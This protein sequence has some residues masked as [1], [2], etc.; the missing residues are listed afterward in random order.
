M[1]FFFRRPDAPTE[2]DS[3]SCSIR[4]SSISDGSV[5]SVDRGDLS[6]GG[7]DDGSSQASD[8]KVQHILSGSETSRVNMQTLWLLVA[9]DILL[10]AKRTD[11]EETIGGAATGSCCPVKLHPSR[12][13]IELR[14]EP[15]P[16]A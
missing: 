6:C 14:T 1:P 3:L 12:P 4:D 13:A 11:L 5:G 10:G 16:E 8:S 7:G 15:Q 9:L 2:E